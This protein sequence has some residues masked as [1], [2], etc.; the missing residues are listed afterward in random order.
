MSAQAAT[1]AA[2]L[3]GWF[4]LPGGHAEGD[5]ISRLVYIGVCTIAA[6]V[7]FIGGWAAFAPLSGAVI[8]PGFVKVDMNRKLVQHQE[9]GIVKQILVRDGQQVT[10]GQL[11]MEIDDVRVDAS[12]DLMRQ[13]LDEE[14][15][16]AAR[17]EAERALAPA[18][19]FPADI[20]RRTSEPKVV[21]IITRETALFRARREAL[22][23]Q[24]A[25]LR[26]Q[27]AEGQ[28]EVAALADQVAAEARAMK[29]QKDELEAN[30][31]LVK[32]N[33]IAKTRVLTLQRAVAEYEARHGEHRA[34][35]SKTRQRTAELELRIQSMRNDY[36]KVATNE[37]KDSTSKIFDLEERVRPTRDAAERQKILAPIAGEVVGM[38]VFSPGGVVGPREVLMEL[39]PAVKTL[40]VEAHLRPED[41]N[42][43]RAGTIADVRLTSYKQRNTQL[44]EGKVSYVSGDRLIDPGPNGTPYYLVQ[45]EVPP[46]ALSAAGNLTMQAGMPAEVFLRTDSRTAFDYLFAPITT[47]LARGMRE[48]L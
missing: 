19:S 42:H 13:Q 43:V 1:L 30:E 40:V 10:Q 48:P 21:E 6:A 20:A 23:T 14:R 3:R 18:P 41:I 28:T 45:I 35:M 26:R 31:E 17:L 4:V 22:D 11:L 38:K 5:D 9:G 47:Y 29:L 44:V 7:V 2:R 15:I 37:L 8:A 36:V 39:V 33:F 25:L 34:E 12:F 16:K 32:Q 27:I 46:Q 24:V